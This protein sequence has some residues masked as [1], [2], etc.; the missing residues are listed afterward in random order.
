MLLG[1]TVL[2]EVCLALRHV[3]T[4]ILWNLRY[5]APQCS[6]QPAVTAMPKTYLQNRAV[7]NGMPPRDANSHNFLVLPL[8]FLS[9]CLWVKFQPGLTVIQGAQNFVL[10]LRDGVFHSM[11]VSFAL[12]DASHLPLRRC[13]VKSVDSKPS[14]VLPKWLRLN[15]TW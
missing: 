13:C 2:C 4:H 9:I 1:L 15:P 5:I 11:R 8:D 10:L 3:V 12:C 6:F 7:T 14:F